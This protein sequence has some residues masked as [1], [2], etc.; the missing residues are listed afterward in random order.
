MSE[1]KKCKVNLPKDWTV[2]T[3]NSHPDRVYYFNVRTGASSW[4]EPRHDVNMSRPAKLTS[5]RKLSPDI[6]PGEIAVRKSPTTELSPRQLLSAKR[7][8][9]VNVPIDTPQMQ[10][11]RQKMQKKNKSVPNEKAKSN[12][13]AK[14]KNNYAVSTSAKGPGKSNDLQQSQR[15]E[16]AVVGAAKAV[17]S[18]ST[19]RLRSQASRV[20]QTSDIPKSRDTR[21]TVLK[22]N[23]ASKRLDSLKKNLNESRKKIEPTISALVAQ[24]LLTQK[25][26]MANNDKNKLGNEMREARTIIP[27]PSNAYKEGSPLDDLVTKV[28]FKPKIRKKKKS[29]TVANTGGESAAGPQQPIPQPEEEQ[30][31]FWEEMDWEPIEEEKL[32]VQIQE[33][34]MQLHSNEGVLSKELPDYT[35][36]GLDLSHVSANK[37]T[38]ITYIVVDTNVFLSNLKTIVDILENPGQLGVVVVPWTVLQELDY[39]KDNKSKSKTVHL[40]HSARLAVNLLFQCFSSKHPRVKGQSA[41]DAARIKRNFE[42]E[43][44]D[45]EILQSCMQIR[46]LGCTVVLLSNDKNLCN[47]AMIHDIPTYGRHH[48]IQELLTPKTKASEYRDPNSNLKTFTMN[49]NELVTTDEV[50]ISDE[51]YGEAKAVVKN[52]LSTI[53]S[54]EME[55]LYEKNWEKHTIVQPPWSV[56]DV[57]KCATKHWIAA[58]SN[59]FVRSAKSQMEKLSEMFKDAPKY[60]QSLKYVSEVLDVCQNLVQ[61]VDSKKYAQLANETFSQIQELVKVCQLKSQELKEKRIVS[62]LCNEKNLSNYGKKADKAFSFLEKIWNFTNNFCGMTTNLTEMP[63]DPVYKRFNQELTPEVMNELQP[64]ISSSLTRLINALQTVLNDD[65]F[66]SLSHPA[67]IELYR[68][69]MSYFP[70]GGEL[71]DSCSLELEDVFCCVLTRSDALKSGLTQ[72]RE[73]N[74]HICCMAQHRL[75]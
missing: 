36:S 32:V 27:E 43:S 42:I 6:D 24:R 23:I 63:H 48:S 45:D 26:D 38:E 68:S 13:A 57:L 72:L 46:E 56:M 53:V 9:R 29:A 20:R 39:I 69:L 14:N 15:R 41:E 54:T 33:V 31:T 1:E 7:R 61:L 40:Q 67:L 17:T 59:A 73:L 49:Y 8:S 71:N 51:I 25:S 70:N 37:E 65:V 58:I 22:K 62:Y 74:R 30:N 10:M 28:P 66:L 5:K 2:V 44:P 11:M 52:F 64:A 3:S 16:S 55:N 18:S 4:T 47:K 60:G 75:E 12:K 50:Q 19:C 34:R 21:N 35:S